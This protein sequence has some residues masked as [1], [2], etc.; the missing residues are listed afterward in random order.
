MM[1][2]INNYYL[3]IQS[4]FKGKTNSTLLQ[5][6]RF[7]FA[8]VF[9]FSADFGTL[10]ILT[11]YFKIYYLVSAGIAFLFG[12]LIKYLLSVI[13]VF[14]IRVVKNRFL[15]FL[16]FALIGLVGLGLNLFFIWIFTDI[17][18]VYYLLSKVF[19]TFIVFFWNFFARKVTLFSKH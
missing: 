19:S 18:H 2:R 15:E 17:L 11:E 12:L 10:F 7:T 8:S 3:K 9:A 16:F 1:W 14:E 4:F 13:W 6:F 5:L